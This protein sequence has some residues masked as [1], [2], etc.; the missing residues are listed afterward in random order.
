[1]KVFLLQRV[2]SVFVFSNYLQRHLILVER[3]NLFT[4][5]HTACCLDCTSKALLLVVNWVV[6]WLTYIPTQME[7]G[8]CV[9]LLCIHPWACG[10][11]L[12]MSTYS[13]IQISSEL[14]QSQKWGDFTATNWGQVAVDP[15]R[16]SI[17][18]LPLCSSCLCLKPNNRFSLTFILMIRGVL[19]HRWEEL[20]LKHQRCLVFHLEK[21]E[22]LKAPFWWI[23]EN[24]S[25]RWR[26]K[27]FQC[28]SGRGERRS[29]IGEA[30]DV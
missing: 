5:S 18:S 14:K 7:K 16:N 20:A 22:V 12:S 17:S 1:M 2:F 30:E 25:W 15:S 21:A 10:V 19:S 28:D 8:L 27:E 4:G 11:T 3:N 24:A 9:E 13:E 26:G 23:I 6:R 29:Q